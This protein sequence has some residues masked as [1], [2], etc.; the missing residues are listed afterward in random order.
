MRTTHDDRPAD[1]GVAGG[2]RL[3]DLHR[4]RSVRPAGHQHAQ[5]RRDDMAGDPDTPLRFGLGVHPRAPPQ[6]FQ[7]GGDP[8]HALDLLRRSVRPRGQ[9]VHPYGPGRLPSVPMAYL[10]LL[11]LRHAA[12]RGQHAAD[13]AVLCTGDEN[14]VP[15][16]LRP[17]IC[18]IPLHRHL[19]VGVRN[20]ADDP[21]T[22][23]RTVHP[24]VQ[25]LL[26]ADAAR[27]HLYGIRI[28]E[29]VRAEEE[30]RRPA[31]AAGRHA[32][33]CLC[34]FR[35]PGLVD[36]HLL[37]GRPR[38]IQ[39]GAQYPR[40]ECEERTDRKIVPRRRC[41]ERHPE[42]DHGCGLPGGRNG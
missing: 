18:G 17:Q 42:R 36:G 13:A 25:L 31:H 32:A 34:L 28:P 41:A 26:H 27:L 15:Q 4:R 19:P 5:G 37:S 38:K 6:I 12:P 35:S 24:V 1:L 29:T 8:A 30:R 39:G 11:R 10:L 7:P 9:G 22:A 16:A 14:R 23:C 21:R 40:Q 33:I 3:F 2:Q 20:H